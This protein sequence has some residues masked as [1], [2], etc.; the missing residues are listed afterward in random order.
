MAQTTTETTEAEGGA[1]GVFPPFDTK[2]F[3]SQILWLVVFF[4]ALY[5]LMGRWILPKLGTVI[6]ARKAQIDS[7]FSRAY[8][9]KEETEAAVKHY[10]KALADA[11]AN[12]NDIARDTKEKVTAEID[13]EQSV[14]DGELAKKIKDAEARVAKAKAKAMESVE[15]IAG[16]SAADIVASLT[17]GKTTKTAVAK[18]IA[19]IKR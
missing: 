13:G 5:L 2:A 8:A 9:L 6:A 11:K 1:K 16:E 7:D 10:E 17:G 14:L 12:A 3:P 15:L 4:T 19:G 18:A